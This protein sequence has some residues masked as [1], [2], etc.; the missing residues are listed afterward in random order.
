MVPE[1]KAE[2]VAT[3]RIEQLAVPGGQFNVHWQDRFSPKEQRRLRLWLSDAAESA[4]LLSGSFPGRQTNIFLHRS[5]S[6]KGPVPWA[7][8][9]RAEA[10]EGV[11]FHVQPR[12]K[13]RQFIADWTATHEFSHLYL[14]YVGRD[15]IWLAEGFASYY[16]YI[17]MMRR[18][19]LSEA[20]GWQKFV[21]GLSRGENDPYQ[22]GPLHLASRLMREKRAYKRVY[23]S[24]ALYFLAVDLDLR[25]QGSS[26]DQ[27]IEKFQSCC[28][29]QAGPWSGKRLVAQLDQ[30]GAT[31]VFSEKFRR[32]ENITGFPDYQP[33]LRRLGI[34]WQG[35][36]IQLS[37]ATNAAKLRRS[38]SQPQSTGRVR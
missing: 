3:P 33:L 15:D 29:H 24:G 31:R 26:L 9:V 2:P 36:R 4:S 8:T 25:A 5:T 16:Q 7:H 18:G 28:R 1:A 21:D 20:V 23:W 27:V 6:G 37:E 11:V 14:P 12:K 22:Q 30:A 17:L 13:L 10:P 19:T 32:F 38:I 34:T 35:K